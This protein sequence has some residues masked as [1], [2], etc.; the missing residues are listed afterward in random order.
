[1]T[2]AN[3]LTLTADVLEKIAAYLD[4]VETGKQNAEKAVRV[5]AATDLSTRLSSAL[6]ETVS[7]DVVEKLAQIPEAHALLSRLAGGNDVDSLGG[8]E[9][10][11]SKTASTRGQTSDA[12]KAFVEWC[13]S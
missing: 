1:M 3:Y 9:T 8:P 4:S 5:K 7:P 13:V 11:N 10:T 6:G 2:G 12:D